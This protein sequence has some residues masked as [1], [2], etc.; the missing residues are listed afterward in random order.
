[1]V[2]ALLLA[3]ASALLGRRMAA[4]KLVIAMPRAGRVARRAV[5]IPA[6]VL[7]P[8]VLVAFLTQ[9]H[10]EVVVLDIALW[11]AQGLLALFFLAA[12]LPK[13]AGRGLDRWVGLEDFSRG[14]TILIGMSE[15]VGAVALVLPSLVGAFEWTVPLAA[16]GIAVISLMASGFHVRAAERISTI[17]TALL[18]TLAGSIAIG[19]WEET[20][21]A[22]A[23]PA[24][25]LVIVIALLV[26]S[27][28][29]VLVVLVTRPGAQG[30]AAG[31]QRVA[32]G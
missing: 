26:P 29:A 25:V 22:P 11:V 16:I 27:I 9:R 5:L 17:E 15:V 23:V 19:R 12:G 4:R 20:A 7:V 1:V 31:S 18:A 30:G 32:A 13:V 2:V 3:A 14:L 6:G 8:G 10:P 21:S 24:G 28:I